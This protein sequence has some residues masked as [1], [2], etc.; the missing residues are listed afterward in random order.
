[1][2]SHQYAWYSFQTAPNHHLMSCII[3]KSMSTVMS[4]I[5]CFLIREREFV[6][7][8]RSILREYADIR[9]DTADNE[10]YLNYEIM[11]KITS[12]RTFQ[13]RK[14]LLKVS[15]EFWRFLR[16]KKSRRVRLSYASTWWHSVPKEKKTES[17]VNSFKISK[18]GKVRALDLTKMIEVLSKG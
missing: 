15:P 1:M 7:A 10:P 5:F 16:W 2:V 4:A 9:W 3:Q 18:S 8:G 6:D 14:P 13:H 17:Y 12:I 11:Q